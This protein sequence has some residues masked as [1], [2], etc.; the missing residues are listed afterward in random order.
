MGVP[1]VSNKEVKVTMNDLAPEYRKYIHLLKSQVAGL[2]EAAQQHAQNVVTLVKQMEEHRMPGESLP[3][4][5]L[6]A[7]MRAEVTLKRPDHGD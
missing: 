1:Q 7:K 5:V 6:A 4:W 3:R 2:K